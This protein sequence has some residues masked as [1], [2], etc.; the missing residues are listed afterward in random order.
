MVKHIKCASGVQ[1]ICCIHDVVTTQKIAMTT[2][3]LGL[4]TFSKTKNKGDMKT[5]AITH[6]H[7]Y[8]DFNTN[9]LR[10]FRCFHFQLVL[11]L[12]ISTTEEF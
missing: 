5:N 9:G 1:H 7:L 2:P 3:N 10:D 11:P 8:L 4:Y 6:F 12:Y